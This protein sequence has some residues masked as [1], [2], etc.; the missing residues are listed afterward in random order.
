M[1]HLLMK[2]RRPLWPPRGAS[3][4]YYVQQSNAKDQ[5]GKNLRERLNIIIRYA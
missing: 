2:N 3:S 4:K 1:T 5:I